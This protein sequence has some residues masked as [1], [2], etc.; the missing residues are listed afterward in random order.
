[1]DAD[2]VLSPV[3]DPIIPRLTA[4]AARDIAF[5]A[6]QEELELVGARNWRWG[7]RWVHL[8][9]V[10]GNV[11]VYQVHVRAQRV[12][13]FFSG[14]ITEELIIDVDPLAGQVVGIHRI[15]HRKG[16]G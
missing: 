12:S 1:M 14:D 15:A 7:S 5:Q 2:E 4:F 8:E 3:A 13:W 10:A 16:E 9:M 11:L 6:A